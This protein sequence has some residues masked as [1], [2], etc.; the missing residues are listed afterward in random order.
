MLH[1]LNKKSPSCEALVPQ[2]NILQ[3]GIL[4]RSRSSGVTSTAPGVASQ[5]STGWRRLPFGIFTVRSLRTSLRPSF[6]VISV[7]FVPTLFPISITLKVFSATKVRLNEQKTKFWSSKCREMLALP[8]LS[9][10]KIRQLVKFYLSFLD[11]EYL[12]HQ[13]KSKVHVHAG[14]TCNLL[15]AKTSQ[16]VCP[17]VRLR[18]MRH[19]ADAFR[20]KT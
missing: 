3:T 15:Q 4:I 20:I 11:C 12:R 14:T 19:H 16:G 13:S 18:C 5:Q 1:K 10:D 17:P 9:R 2:I 8:L 6:V 7:S